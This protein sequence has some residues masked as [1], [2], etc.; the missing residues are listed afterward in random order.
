[1]QSPRHLLWALPLLL[2]GLPPS[3][4]ADVSAWFVPSGAKVLRDAKP[5]PQARQGELA[6]AR[7][8]TEAC[9]LVLRSD[10]PVADVVVSAGELR[11]ADGSAG[12]RPELRKVEYVPN[13][14]RGLPYPDPLPP[15]RPLRLEAGQAQP[16]WISVKVPKGAKPGDY[17]GTVRLSA[18]GRRAEFRLRLHV[19]GFT[20][21]D[22]PASATAFGLSRE[23]IAQRHGVPPHSPAGQRLYEAY[24]EMLLDH[25]I[26]AYDI[27]VDL[28]SDA[29]AKY[30]NDPRMTSYMIPYPNDD[31]ALRAIVARLLK[32]GWYA[33]G[34]FYPIDEPVNKQAY[35]TLAQISERLNRCA[36]GYHWAVPFFRRPDWDGRITA[37]DLMANRV[38]IWCPN[39]PHFDAD[40]AARPSMT[41]R[42]VLG[43]RLWWYVC[44]GPGEPYNNFFVSM[45]A[46]SHR[47]L[48]WQQKREN[49]EGLL[50]WS[51]TWWSTT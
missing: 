45:P 51:T 8:E 31:A 40:P 32:N 18:E 21:P 42:H 11:L 49:I 16:V 7:N 10:R 26:S 1:M 17:A 37:F 38:N 13:I 36:P 30:L 46:M 22:T 50:Y 15:L 24:Y 9:Q 19:W 29:A 35:T 47:V 23:C 39:T 28:M 4:L 6:A 25:R 3:A 48:F 14:F 33:K 34:Y 20:L 5:N 12:L 2:G 44:C 27:P 41:A 43:D